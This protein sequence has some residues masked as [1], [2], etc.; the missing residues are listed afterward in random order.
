MPWAVWSLTNAGFSPGCRRVW[1]QV[2]VQ[3]GYPFGWA[4]CIKGIW[5]SVLMQ[6]L[7]DPIIHDEIVQVGDFNCIRLVLT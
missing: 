5:F 3:C 2:L 1:F 7:G 6:F 4:F